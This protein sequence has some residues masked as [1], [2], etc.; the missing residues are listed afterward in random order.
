MIIGKDQEK[1]HGLISKTKKEIGYSRRNE[2]LSELIMCDRCKNKYYT[3]SRSD[4]GAYCEMRIIYTNGNG[5]MHL[6]KSCFRLFNTDFMRVYTEKEFDE[7]F[8]KNMP[9]TFDKDC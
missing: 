2:G 5:T 4:K 1:M 7:E 9:K 6:C 3:D 8:G